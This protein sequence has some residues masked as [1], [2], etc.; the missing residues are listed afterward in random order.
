MYGKEG[1]NITIKITWND[2][3]RLI[4]TVPLN[5]AHFSWLW[6]V[7]PATIKP[8]TNESSAIYQILEKVL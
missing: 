2:L 6:I 4:G 1:D 7:R 3:L 5:Y 8:N